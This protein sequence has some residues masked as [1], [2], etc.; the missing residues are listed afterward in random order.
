MLWHIKRFN[1][2][3][4]NISKLYFT[5]FQFLTSGGALGNFDFEAHFFKGRSQLHICEVWKYWTK[6]K[7]WKETCCDHWANSCYDKINETTAAVLNTLCNASIWHE[8]SMLSYCNASR[9]TL[10]IWSVL[11]NVHSAFDAIIH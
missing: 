11:I 6:R 2:R 5:W 8:L 9:G 7:Q 1:N 10:L 3:M 4:I